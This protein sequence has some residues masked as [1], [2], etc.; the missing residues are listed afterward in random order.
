MVTN[1]DKP[2]ASRYSNEGKRKR[3]DCNAT[4]SEKRKHPANGSAQSQGQP[5]TT[6]KPSIVKSMRPRTVRSARAAGSQER[7]EES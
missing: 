7:N 6:R 5:S 4:Q 1:T 2:S 3:E